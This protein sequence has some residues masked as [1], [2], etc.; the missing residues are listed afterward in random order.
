MEH[1]RFMEEKEMTGIFATR[2]MRLSE[3]VSSVLQDRNVY[4]GY[5]SGAPRGMLP[6]KDIGP[7]NQADLVFCSKWDGQDCKA[8]VP[9][10]NKVSWNFPGGLTSSK[11]D[12]ARLGRDIKLYKCAPNNPVPSLADGV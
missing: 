12:Y 8:I 9:I 2:M 4:A 10:E 5:K 1:Q 7:D 6:R 3:V 11:Q